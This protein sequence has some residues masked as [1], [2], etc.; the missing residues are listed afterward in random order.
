[1]LFFSL[2][3][4]VESFT[5]LEHKLSSQALDQESKLEP[6]KKVIEELKSQI[7]EVCC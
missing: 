2:R 5:G 1:M 6:Q 7:N 3:L 4:Y